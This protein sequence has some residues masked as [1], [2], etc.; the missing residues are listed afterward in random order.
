MVTLA[1][2]T[3][4]ECRQPAPL[5]RLTSAKL[6]VKQQLKHFHRS[7]KKFKRNLQIAA[8]EELLR[9]PPRAPLTPQ[10]RP[11]G[12]QE[13]PS[14][15]SIRLQSDCNN[16]NNISH[17]QQDTCGQPSSFATNHDPVYLED[18]QV[19]YN[20]I[21][22]E[23]AE[24]ER[25]QLMA[26]SRRVGLGKAALFEDDQDRKS[27]EMAAQE[28]LLGGQMR[29]SLLSWMLKVCEH[30]Q[31]QD[32]I[33]PLA[34]M[35]LDKFLLFQEP[36]GFSAGSE[37]P[38]LDGSLSSLGGQSMAAAAEDDSG[39]DN[40]GEQEFHCAEQEELN[41]R[42]LYLFAACS[43]LLATK[44]RQTPRLSIQS[45]VEFSRFELPVE[46][47]R[48][49]IQSGEILILSSL[50]WDLA[51]LVTPNDFLTIVLEKCRKLLLI[52]SSADKQADRLSP[53]VRR[54]SKAEVE[55]TRQAR[56]AVAS[57]QSS[58]S[59]SIDNDIS[60]SAN[61][62]SGSRCDESKIKRH[63]QSLVELCLMGK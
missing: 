41:R 13:T 59:N 18:D 58:D 39:L 6:N 57:E 61:V 29:H 24:Q 50:K 21:L 2:L 52:R 47:E 56:K 55:E 25:R 48:A 10:E 26:L 3:N 36:S 5:A 23:S 14:L 12:H 53:T 33:F 51:S 8:E 45:L 62:S 43:L 16:N 38:F 20:L 35:I 1:S 49:E 40:A 34:C 54:G 42:Q 7:S 17:H 30:Q 46:L 32:D 22:K 28:G 44:L 9:A 60:G 15:C 31:C 19:F 37:A 11:F 27:V 4:C 63:I